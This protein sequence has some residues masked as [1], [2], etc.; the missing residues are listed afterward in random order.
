MNSTKD[1]YEWYPVLAKANPVTGDFRPQALNKNEATG[2][3]S[4]YKVYLRTGKDGLKYN[5]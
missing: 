2:L 3:A 4:K 5:T 1:G